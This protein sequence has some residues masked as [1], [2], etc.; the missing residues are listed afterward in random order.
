MKKGKKMTETKNTENAIVPFNAANYEVLDPDNLKTLGDVV[1]QN[2][3]TGSMTPRKFFPQIKMPLL[4][5][6]EW[7]IPT[8]DGDVD[9]KMFSGIIIH[10]QVE[11]GLFPKPYKPGSLPFCSSENGVIGI[12]NP[13][14]ECGSCPN[15]QFGPDGTPPECAQKKAIYILMKEEIVPMVLRIT[16][17]SFKAF[18]DY[19]LKVSRKLKPLHAIETNFS[20]KSTVAKGSGTTVSEV[21]FEIGS[22]LDKEDVGKVNAVKREILPFIAPHLEERR[23]DELAA[24]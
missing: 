9:C 18:E 24:A 19:L 11:R 8:T 14:G 5:N 13:G 4:G 10:V 3:D 16:P 20:L 22:P 6:K 12:G 7:V 23:N 21:V 15:A 2:L 17:S 1:A